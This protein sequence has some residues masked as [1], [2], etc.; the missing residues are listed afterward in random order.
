MVRLHMKRCLGIENRFWSKVDKSG[1]PNACW[2][3]KAARTMK[4]Y[5]RFQL[6][7]HWFQASRM[8]YMLTT[9]RPLLEKMACHNCPGGDNPRCC[10]PK[11]IFPGTY[12]E[13]ARDTKKKGQYAT[14][15]RHGLHLHPESVSR[16][17][18]RPLAK[19]NAAKV[20]RMRKMWSQHKLSIKAIGVKFQVSEMAAWKVI[21][22]RAWKHVT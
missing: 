1:G 9:H 13:H 3:W 18:H 20:R 6:G 4:D 14:G 22:Q 21:H 12:K 7:G 10:N 8:A 15:K 17:E 2:P 16:G 5:G 11:H 19:L